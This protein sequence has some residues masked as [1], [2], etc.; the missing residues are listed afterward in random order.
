MKIMIGNN[1]PS[2]K[3]NN[4]I[5]IEGKFFRCAQIDD[6]GF[7]SMDILKLIQE[8]FTQVKV[9]SFDYCMDIQ[10]PKEH[11]DF[12]STIYLEAFRIRTVGYT[13]FKSVS[14]N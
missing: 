6:F 10:I 5:V 14:N 13:H 4:K 9:L 8:H 2:A 12:L 3:F 7:T 11:T 1:S